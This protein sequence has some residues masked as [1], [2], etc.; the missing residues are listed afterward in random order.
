MIAGMNEKCQVMSKFKTILN[1]III[2][3]ILNEL[4]SSTIRL[5]ADVPA[6]ASADVVKHLLTQ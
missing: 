3:N 5:T 1:N 2:I 4:P 6:A